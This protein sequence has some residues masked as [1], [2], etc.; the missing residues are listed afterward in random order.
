MKREEYKSEQTLLDWLKSMGCIFYAPFTYGDLTDHIS[1]STLVDPSGT[2]VEWDST[3]QMY[4]FLKTAKS[5]EKYFPVNL[6]YNAQTNPRG[7]QRL[8]TQDYTIVGYTM[9]TEITAYGYPPYIVI[10]SYKDTADYIPSLAS[11]RE[12][13]DRES[14]RA[15][16]LRKSSMTQHI[17]Y[18]DN[19][20]I[21]YFSNLAIASNSRAMLSNIQE[22]MFSKVTINPKRDNN[23]PITMNCYVKDAM[24][25]NRA[26]TDTEL[27]AI[28][29]LNTD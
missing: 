1:G 22:S 28:G 23:D 25:F 6:L 14:A 19:N 16:F 8:E 9:R 21:G 17:G 11:I 13:T 15:R 20:A 10:G 29:F 27:I 3:M 4:K 12:E 26:L 5:Q 24:I 2:S 7:L 18:C